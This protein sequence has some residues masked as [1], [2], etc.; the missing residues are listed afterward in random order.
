M[1]TKKW[2][3]WAG[4]LGTVAAIIMACPVAWNMNRAAVAVMDTPNEVKRIQAS[5]VTLRSELRADLTNE[6]IPP[7][8]DLKQR[9][10]KLEASQ[11]VKYPKT[12]LMDTIRKQ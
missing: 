1:K 9:V 6:F 10:G 2:T 7:L 8:E 5:I 12:G 11:A 3:F 4:I